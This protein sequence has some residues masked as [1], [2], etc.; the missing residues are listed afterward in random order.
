MSETTLELNKGAG[1]EMV[2]QVD[3]ITNNGIGNQIVDA[4]ITEIVFSISEDKNI[5]AVVTATLSGAEI[6]S[7][8]NGDGFL[9]AIVVTISAAKMA[10]TT[11]GLMIG[12]VQ[13]T[14]SSSP[15]PFVTSFFNVRIEG[16]I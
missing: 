6:T 16:V 5:A 14:T 1:I 8:V 9:D 4:D 13:I 12:Q 7:E 11:I 10:S 3:L 15:T 2:A